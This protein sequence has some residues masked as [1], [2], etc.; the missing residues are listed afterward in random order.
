[1]HKFLL[2]GTSGR[3]HQDNQK[4]EALSKG[5]TASF[6]FGEVSEKK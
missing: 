4:K 2:N 3:S 1:M 5:E 6:L